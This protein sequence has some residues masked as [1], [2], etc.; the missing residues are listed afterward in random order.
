MGRE[1]VLGKLEPNVKVRVKED[2]ES[3]DDAAVTLPKG[4][5]GKVL[6]IDGEGD[7]FIRFNRDE[8]DDKDVLRQWVFKHTA[9]DKLELPSSPVRM[10]ASR[11][12]TCLDN[13]TISA[14][15]DLQN[16]NK[17]QMKKFQKCAQDCK[18]EACTK[19]KECNKFLVDYN[20]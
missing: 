13:C 7:A 14:K 2:F 3:D 12:V 20:N 10:R 4:M 19:D 16:M 5:R 17:K 1:E 11:V 8:F 18:L 9:F 15:C 6:R